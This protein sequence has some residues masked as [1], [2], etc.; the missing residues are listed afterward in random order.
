MFASPLARYATI[1]PFLG[2][3]YDRRYAV[4]SKH[5]PRAEDRDYGNQVSGIFPKKGLP[6]LLGCEA[7]AFRHSLKLCPHY[8]RMHAA[9]QFFLR[10]TAVGSGNDIFSADTLCEPDDPLGYKLRVF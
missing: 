4:D 2:P 6:K 3:V 7:G 9:I 10:E 5:K 1:S 8:G